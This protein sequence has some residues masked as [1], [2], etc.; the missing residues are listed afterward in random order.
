MTATLIQSPDRVL[1]NNISWQ[2][3]QFLVK[4]FEQE[5]HPKQHQHIYHHLL[6]N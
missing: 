3:Y 2:T 4:D 1:L 6:I 5:L